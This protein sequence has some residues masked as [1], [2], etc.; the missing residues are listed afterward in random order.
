MI[1]NA[2]VAIFEICGVIVVLIL[3]H[4]IL[5]FNEGMK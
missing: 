5:Y 4:A 1:G 3:L 2:L